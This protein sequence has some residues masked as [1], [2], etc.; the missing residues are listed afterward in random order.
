MP[1][2]RR[3]LVTAIGAV[4]VVASALLAWNAPTVRAP[5]A[6]TWTAVT[7]FEPGPPALDAWIV[8]GEEF[9]PPA[10]EMFAAAVEPPEVAVAVATPVAEPAPLPPEFVEAWRAYWAWMDA[11]NASRATEPQTSATPTKPTPTTTPAPKPA[12]QPA[13]RPP[14][15]VADAT[16]PSP[17]PKPRPPPDYDKDGIV[18][19]KDKCPRR[20]ETVNGF[21][22]DDGC[23][24]VVA[25]TR[26]S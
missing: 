14:P 11:V 23:P 13:P 17:A 6:A 26:A 3:R 1:G 19:A 4:A 18:D 2:D 21:Q 12:P 5:P 20:P 8:T 9:G 15:A 16:A 24:E 25:T 7:Y 22:D 10:P